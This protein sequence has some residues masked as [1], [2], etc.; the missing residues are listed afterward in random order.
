MFLLRVKFL[1]P[2]ETKIEALLE[3]LAYEIT[4]FHNDLVY[5]QDFLFFLFQHM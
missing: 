5:F 4:I 1:H 3:Q 2:L